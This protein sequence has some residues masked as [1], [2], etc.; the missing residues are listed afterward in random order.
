MTVQRAIVKGRALDLV[1]TRSMFTCDVVESG[2]DTYDILW[3]AYLQ[4]MYDSFEYIWSASWSTE[5]AELQTWTLGH[6][7][8]FD[9]LDFVNAGADLADS[10]PNAVSLVL[11]GKA[12]GLRKMGRKFIGGL[13]ENVVTGNALTVGALVYAANALVA[14]ITPFT[15]IGGGT[16][17]PGIVDKYGTF[18]PFVGGIVSSILGSMRKRKPG[19]GI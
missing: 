5:T 16:I 11:I 17:T 10:I 7:V 4:S 15:G 13:S 12:A 1:N 19:V 2:G 14:Y 6:W 18:Q 9:E 3:G 8:T